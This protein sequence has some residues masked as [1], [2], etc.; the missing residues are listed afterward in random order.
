VRAKIARDRVDG[1]IFLFD[2]ERE[3]WPHGCS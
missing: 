1:L 3:G 2:A